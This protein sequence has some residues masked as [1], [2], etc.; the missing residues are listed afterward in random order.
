MALAAA[1]RLLVGAGEDRAV[2]DLDR[3]VAGRGPSAPRPEVA[4]QG[5]LATSW[6]DTLWVD[7]RGRLF[8]DGIPAAWFGQ[9]FDAYGLPV[10]PATALSLAV[11]WH[12]PRP[13]VLWEQLGDPVTLTAPTVAPDWATGE[14]AGEALW[15]PPPSPH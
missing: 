12:G 9:S 11:R 1:R 5:V 2:G 7:D 3:I 14:A 8:P 6:L 13:A 10:G 15:P 4:P